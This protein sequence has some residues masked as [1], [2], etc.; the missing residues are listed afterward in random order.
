MSVKIILR[1]YYYNNIIVL[2]QCN[3]DFK[4]PKKILLV[5]PTYFLHII[6][7]YNF[8]DKSLRSPIEFGYYVQIIFIR[9]I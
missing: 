4:S 9:L 6:I 2:R 3:Y 7:E 5:K 1:R 8:I